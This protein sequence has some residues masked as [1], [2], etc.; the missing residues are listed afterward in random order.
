MKSRRLLALP[1]LLFA[2]YSLAQTPLDTDNDGLISRY[3]F[4]QQAAERFTRLDSD[5]DGYLSRDELRD[6]RPRMRGRRA[7]AFAEADV[8]RDGALSLSEIQTVRPGITPEQFAELDQNGDGLITADERP[9]RPGR[10]WRF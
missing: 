7:A 8:D 3:E 5:G 2:G 10:F 6:G 1:A 4:E 9:G